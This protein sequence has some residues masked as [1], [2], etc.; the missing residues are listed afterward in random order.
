MKM[1]TLTGLLAASTIFASGAAHADLFYVNVNGF[2]TTPF[3]GTDGKTAII[4]ELNINVFATST[5][6]D[7]DANGVDVGDKVVDNG[8]GKVDGYLLGGFGVSGGAEAN[9][10][11]G[12]T[13]SMII[14]YNDLTGVVAAIDPGNPGGIAAFYNSGTIHVYADNNADGDHADAGENEILTL[15]V[16]GSTGTLLNALIFATV[17]A[18]DTNIWFFPPAVDWST[19]TV[20]INMTYDTN[21]YGPVPTAT[22]NPNEYAR[23][24][25]LNGSAT[26]TAVPEPSAL[27][28]LGIGLVG[29]GAIRRNKK[30]A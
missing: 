24:S 12:V 23:S 18:A 5:Y 27:A 30:A 10:G 21:V 19:L 15:D 9:E 4:D 8:L 14:E 20:A 29:L 22:G 2:D 17:T 1:K 28:L 26:F 25:R 13:H 7:L 16:F 11:I 6:T 3:P